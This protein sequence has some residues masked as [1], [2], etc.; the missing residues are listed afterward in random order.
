LAKNSKSKNYSKTREFVKTLRSGETLSGWESRCKKTAKIDFE[1]QNDFGTKKLEEKK[2][3]R[4][5]GSILVRHFLNPLFDF[6]RLILFITATSILRKS[7][8]DFRHLLTLELIL[9]LQTNP[10]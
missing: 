2:H 6:S 10:T 9:F 3:P 4:I 1:T 8:E 5:D 7:Y